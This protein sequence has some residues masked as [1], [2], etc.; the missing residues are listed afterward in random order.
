MPSEDGQVSPVQ[1]GHAKRLAYGILYGMGVNA[2]AT[3]LEC[4]AATASKMRDDFLSSL[5]AVVTRPCLQS[6]PCASFNILDLCA[7][8]VSFRSVASCFDF[9][10][11]DQ[12]S[13]REG[14]GIDFPG[15]F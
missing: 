11:G 3:Q 4:T 10:M 8:V 13:W 5:P 12:A 6:S 14:V 15:S 7:T 2:L 1:R 9:V